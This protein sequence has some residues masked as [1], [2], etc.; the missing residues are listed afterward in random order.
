[1]SE[2]KVNL[3][4]IKQAVKHA[5]YQQRARK[6]QR[7]EKAF[8]FF[9]GL[10]TLDPKLAS[11]NAV[12]EEYVNGISSP[13]MAMS[14]RVAYMMIAMCSYINPHRILDL[15]S[16]FSSYL[17]RSWAKTENREVEVYS[18]D[19]NEFWLL[20]TEEF[21]VKHSLDAVNLLAWSAFQE[22]PKTKWDLIFYDLGSME[23]RIQNFE[24]VINQGALIVV[25]D[26]HKSS[27]ATHIKQV[28][29]QQQYG[30]HEF[31]NLEAY[32][33][34]KFGRYSGLVQG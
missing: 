12:Y 17:F 10:R 1:M 21:L 33:L 8:P 18:I 28:L 2:S 14:L 13:E 16:G 30:N 27:Y 23:T 19:D 32:T 25:D 7:V 5:S 11:I 34:D 9:S 24:Y 6:Q 3:S 26:I 31:F 20:R 29:N 15:G 4:K 22:L